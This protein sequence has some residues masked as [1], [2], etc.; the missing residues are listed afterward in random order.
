MA[1]DWEKSAK[2]C[3]VNMQ[4]F[5]SVFASCHAIDLLLKDRLSTVPHDEGY[6]TKHNYD[7]ILRYLEKTYGTSGLERVALHKISYPKLCAM[8]DTGEIFGLE[9]TRSMAK[10]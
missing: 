6:D 3:C 1:D 4:Y 10:K 9:R 7:I 5:L 8:V 2:L